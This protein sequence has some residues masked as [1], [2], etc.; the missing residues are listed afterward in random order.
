MTDNLSRQ[1][2]SWNMSRIRSK[3][4]APEMVVRKAI[5]SMGYRFRLHEKKLPGKPDI[6]LSKFKVAIFVNGCFWHQHRNCKRSTMPKTNKKYW[7][8]KLE[9]NVRNFED[10]TNQLRKI[11]WRY[12]AIWECETNNAIILF[13]K[14][15]RVLNKWAK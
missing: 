6:V 4:T 5:F 10:A 3:N 11:G 12:T 2:R 15:R 8:A 9:R 1:K 13:K 14:L 7:K